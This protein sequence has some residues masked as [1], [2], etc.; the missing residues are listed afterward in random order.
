MKTFAIEIKWGIRYIFF[1]L[2]WIF[3]EKYSGAYEENIGNYFVFSM[4]FYIFAFLIYILAI[5]DKKE[6]FFVNKMEWKQGCIS[7]IFLT[8]VIALLMPLAQI[9]IHKAIAPE[10]FPN[11]IA[12]GLTSKN[13]D[14]KAL[15]SYFNLTS[16]IWQSIFMTLSVG[17]VYSAVVASF[18]KT[19]K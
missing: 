4:V 2:G 16:Y 14:P 6:N 7:G 15:Q 5:K 9:T 8:I 12:K 3:L 11:M 13:A 1:Y 19:K 18:L 10:F 17:M